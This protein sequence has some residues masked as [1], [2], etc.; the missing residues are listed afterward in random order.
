MFII[1]T[2][3]PYVCLPFLCCVKFCSGCFRQFF[4]IW[5]TKKWSL[6]AL[7]MLSSYA[8]T[9]EWKFA[10]ADSALVVLDKWSSYKGDHLNRFYCMFSCSMYYCDSSYIKPF[11]TTIPTQLGAN[12]SLFF[13][14]THCRVYFPI[15]WELLKLFSWKFAQILLLLLWQSQKRRSCCLVLVAFLLY[16]GSHFR[17]LVHCLRNP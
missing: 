15:S 13:F 1:C 6:V 10:R 14:L 16:F 7:D 8:V 3:L 11:L 9:T 5:K 4:F 2:L 17:L 12:S